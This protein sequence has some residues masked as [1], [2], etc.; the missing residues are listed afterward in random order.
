MLGTC[1]VAGLDTS[2]LVTLSLL[3]MAA[4]YLFF[5]EGKLP[6]DKRGSPASRAC[7]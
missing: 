2:D 3:A 4:H 6:T 7:K 5:W 1:Y